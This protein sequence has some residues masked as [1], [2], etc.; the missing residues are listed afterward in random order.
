MALTRRKWVVLVVFAVLVVVAS[1]LVPLW[2]YDL[3]Q[4]DVM[5]KARDLAGPGRPVKITSAEMHFSFSHGL[6]VLC[7]I[8]G[9]PEISTMVWY[10]LPWREIVVVM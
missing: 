9:V 1:V 8:E 10:L 3:A 4:L 5:A 7:R 2:A 6:W